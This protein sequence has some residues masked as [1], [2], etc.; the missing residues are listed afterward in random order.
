MLILVYKG[1]P[2][3]SQH[4]SSNK[5]H[6]RKKKEKKKAAARS[7]QKE[8]G[9]FNPQTMSVAN[10]SFHVIINVVSIYEQIS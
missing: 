7:I 9:P 6:D 4:S 2:I 3:P 1:A 10:F 8:I 5:A